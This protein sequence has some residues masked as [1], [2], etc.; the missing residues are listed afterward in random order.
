VK[1][2][3]WITFAVW[4]VLY[5]ASLQFFRFKFGLNKIAA[6]FLVIGVLAMLLISRPW[7]AKS[8]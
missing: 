8:K 5:I 3:Q 7:K 4:F 1:K 6:V 2:Q